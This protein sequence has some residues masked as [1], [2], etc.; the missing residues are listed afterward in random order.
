M[1]FDLSTCDVDDRY[2]QKPL[3]LQECTAIEIP[4]NVDLSN[5]LP[6][7][8]VSLRLNCRPL[9]SFC[10]EFIPK[11]LDGLRMV[12]R[13]TSPAA[14]R[15]GVLWLVEFEAI[16]T[17]MDRFIIP[18][19]PVALCSGCC[20]RRAI[21]NACPPQ[22]RCDPVGDFAVFLAPTRPQGSH[23]SASRQSRFQYKN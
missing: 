14:C 4:S 12:L 5:V 10:D 15:A 13:H 21:S 11:D 2:Q 20:P 23:T 18:R 22:L 19:V 17:S 3:S 7:A 1:C 8:L 16:S 9:M 6:I